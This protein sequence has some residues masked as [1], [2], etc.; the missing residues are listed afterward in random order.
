MHGRDAWYAYGVTESGAALP[1][2]VD[3]APLAASVEGFAAGPVQVIVSRVRLA[4]MTGDLP[5][6]PAWLLPRIEAH[7][8]VL[9]AVAAIQPVVPFRFGVLHSTT[10]AMAR[11]VD[12]R[13]DF[14]A[15]TLHRIGQAQEWTVTIAA[16][17]SAADPGAPAAGESR[18]RSYLLARAT[19][20][21]ARDRIHHAVSDVR[22][23]CD[24]WHIPT[25]PLP[26]T[27]DG[28]TRVACL[29]ARTQAADIQ[30]WLESLA[31]GTT[32]VRITLAGP[33]PPYHFVEQHLS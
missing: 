3:P 17:T 12:D 6:D 8:R 27:R 28:S 31:A 25:A 29:L 14:L 16:I 10:D 21:G 1:V 13:A 19:Q 32:G 20:L 5:Q 23:R 9:T 4:E 15:A 24:G 18:G 7:D 26:P 33:L 30:G 22:S 2:G 11:A